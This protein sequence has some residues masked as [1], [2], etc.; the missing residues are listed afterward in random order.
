MNRLRSS[1]IRGFVLLGYVLLVVVGLLSS[2]QS[3]D[4]FQIL[5][6]GGGGMKMVVVDANGDLEPD[7]AAASNGACPLAQVV[8]SPDFHPT[9]TMTVSPLALATRPAVVARLVALAGAPLP[10]RGPPRA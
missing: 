7:S 8:V 1:R 5:C 9:V 3:K 6:L 10:P 2:V 4:S